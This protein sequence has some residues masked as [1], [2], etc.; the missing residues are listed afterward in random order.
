[1]VEISHRQHALFLFS[2]S[3]SCH[4]R[5]V[6]FGSFQ[7]EENLDSTLCGSFSGN[8]R[9]K[10]LMNFFYRLTTFTLNLQEN[11]TQKLADACRPTPDRA[12]RQGRIESCPY[13]PTA[14]FVFEF[15][16]IGCLISTFWW[17]GL[18]DERTAFECV[19]RLEKFPTCF[20][21]VRVADNTPAL[22][23]SDRFLSRIIILSTCA[24]CS[25][26]LDA[27]ACGIVAPMISTKEDA[28]RLVEQCRLLK[29]SCVAVFVSI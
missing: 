1:M 11:Q 7:C 20:P 6:F 13:R 18:L 4:H 16:H 23:R 22:I 19:Q 2:S 12:L 24:L 27:G 15:H 3:T 26:A 29:Y 8:D 14:W 21:I 17:P 5:H 25:R 28:Q 9:M 10:S